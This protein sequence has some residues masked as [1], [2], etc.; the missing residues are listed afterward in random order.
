MAVPVTLTHPSVATA[1]PSSSTSTSS[2]TSASTS[3]LASSQLNMQ[4]FLSLM[5]TQLQNQDPMDPESDS[6]FFAQMAQLGQVEG[7]QQLDNSSSVQQAQALMGQTVTATAT[8]TG[9]NGAQTSQNVTGVVQ[10][11]SVQNGVYYLNVQEA[12]GNIAPVQLS[13]IQ[14][15]QDTP[16]VGSLSDLVGQ[17]VSGSSISGGKAAT[18]SGV[19][20]G[21]TITNGIPTVTIKESNGSTTTL[22]TSSLS[23]IS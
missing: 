13:N 4:Q 12:N 9:T 19:V 5:T 2:S 23:Q 16:N 22:P 7:M 17:T 3:A 18:I 20:T 1:Q 8:T 15:V 6:D 11:L 21:V 14:S 10:S